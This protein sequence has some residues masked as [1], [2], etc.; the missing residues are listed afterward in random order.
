MPCG[1]FVKRPYK[2][3]KAL[4]IKQLLVALLDSDCHSN[5]HT[6]HGVVACDR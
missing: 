3:E 4:K 2:G 1:R 5:R 6:N